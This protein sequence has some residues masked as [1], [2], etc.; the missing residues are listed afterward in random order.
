MSDIEPRPVKS[1]ADALRLA[2]KRR[3]LLEL[4]ESAGRGDHMKLLLGS[5]KTTLPGLGELKTGTFHGMCKQLGSIPTS[6]ERGQ[7]M[8]AYAATLTPDEEDGGFVVTFRDVPEAIT[9]GG[10]LD[11]ALHNAADALTVALEFYARG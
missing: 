1:S 9:Q 2:R 10:T 8:L 3:I 7:L 4:D 11:E 5:R 6:C